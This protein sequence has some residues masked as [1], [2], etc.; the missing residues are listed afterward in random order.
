MYFTACYLIF[1]TNFK[2]TLVLNFLCSLVVSLIAEP[3][4]YKESEFLKT[5]IGFK[6]GQSLV[7]SIIF[8]CFH[9]A[10]VLLV[11][12]LAAIQAQSE[13]Y[14]NLL[15]MMRSGVIL[16]SDKENKILFSNKAAHYFLSIV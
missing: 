15:N 12:M 9:A 13:R 7:F 5:L 4:V 16:A 11:Q 14:Y 2:V 3:L 8:I 10:L 6:I 1:A